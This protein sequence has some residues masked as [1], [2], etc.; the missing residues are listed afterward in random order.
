MLAVQEY[1]IDIRDLHMAYTLDQTGRRRVDA[2]RGVSLRVNPGELFVLLGPSGCGKSTLLRSVAGLEEPQEGSITL[3]RSTV[4]DARSGIHMRAQD[5]GIGMV[6]QDF[7]LY[8]H[9]SVAQN[10]AFGL[11]TRKVPAD[12][13]DRRLAEALRIVEMES[14]AERRPAKLSGGQRQRIA[15]ARA[16]AGD[17]KILL[18]D[19]PLSNLDPLLRTMVRTELKM[20]IRKLGTTSLFVTHDQDEAMVMGDRIAVMNRGTIE[21]TGTPEEIYQSPQTLFVAEFT[22]R[23]STNLI[24]GVVQRHQGRLI[25]VP[26]ESQAQTLTIPE[27]LDVHR[28]QRVTVHARPEDVDIHPNPVESS[29]ALSILSVEPEGSH[30]TVHLRLGGPYK[31]LV[32]RDTHHVYT[33]SA[34]GSGAHVRLLRGTVYSPDTGRLIGSF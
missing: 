30:T 2:L 7:A 24:E 18:F 26:I 15:L 8:P 9:M 17:P 29:T 32:V 3:G 23:P 13:I 20:L 14:F 28:E 34:V 31:P 10:I 21:Q 11:K 12:E 25:L 4:L 5:R 27:S 1:G 16:I 22:G 19:E 33:K 6:F